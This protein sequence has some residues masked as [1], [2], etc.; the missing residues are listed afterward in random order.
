VK[1]RKAGWGELQKGVSF[2]NPFLCVTGKNYTDGLGAHAD[3]EILVQSTEN[4]V[5]FHA[6]VGLDQNKETLS[7]TQVRLIFSVEAK[8]KELWRSGELDIQSEETVDLLLPSETKEIVLK[9]W[10]VD[11]I[12]HRAHTDWA[13]AQVELAGAI[14][15]NWGSSR[16]RSRFQRSHFP[17]FTTADPRVSCYPPWKKVSPRVQVPKR[18]Q[19]N[20]RC[21]GKS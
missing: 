6:I 17:L 4:I 2:E 7:G 3:S 19:H 15:S 14:E 20:I 8:G 5:R 9:A 16:F 18:E 10:S 1:A 13:A 12:I 11:G 21:P